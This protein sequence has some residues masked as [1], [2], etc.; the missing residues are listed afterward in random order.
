MLMQQ[1]NLFINFIT[2]GRNTISKKYLLLLVLLTCCIT[3]KADTISYWHMDYNRLPL[4]TYNETQPVAQRL[5]TLQYAQIKPND[6]LTIHYFRD[7]PCSDCLETYTIKNA[8]AKTL[9]T[10]HTKNTF[11][12][13]LL[14][15]DIL[16]GAMKKSNVR[17]F[18]I[19]K[20]EQNGTETLLFK[21]TLT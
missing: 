20:N 5:V 21:I 17:T 15:M 14:P 6:F 12:P 1:R 3:S 11:D 10:I 4:A 2:M 13:M 9:G 16:T 18:N 19:Y 7:T 8:D